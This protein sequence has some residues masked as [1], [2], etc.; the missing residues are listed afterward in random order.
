MYHFE[1]FETL[2]YHSFFIFAQVHAALGHLVLTDHPRDCRH[3]GSL[4]HHLVLKLNIR[5]SRRRWKQNWRLLKCDSP[6]R[7][8]VS[9][10]APN[11]WKWLVRKNR[12]SDRAQVVQVS[13]PDE[14]TEELASRAEPEVSAVFFEDCRTDNTLFRKKKE[15]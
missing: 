14:M 2:I 9:S 7:Y 4:E 15:A 3:R 10:W 12:Q 11:L 1:S 5:R 6:R 8:S 13:V